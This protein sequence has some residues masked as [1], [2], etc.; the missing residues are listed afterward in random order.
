MVLRG[1]GPINFPC[2]HASI[3]T[4]A[5]YDITKSMVPSNG[6]IVAPKLREGWP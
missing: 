5:F 3:A 6:M 2:S 1:H 4:T